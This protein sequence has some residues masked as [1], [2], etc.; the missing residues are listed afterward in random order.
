[1]PNNQLKGNVF[2]P[3]EIK[4]REFNSKLLL[5]SR[6]IAEGF[7]VYIGEKV[8]LDEYVK[9]S[10]VKG[11]GIY[12]NKSGNIS[13]KL[14]YIEESF[15]AMVVLDEEMGVAVKDLHFRYSERLRNEELISKYFVI[16]S[17]HAEHLKIF[18]KKI[19]EKLVVT[20]WPRVDLWRPMLKNV[21]QKKIDRLI[22]ENGNFILFSSDFGYTSEDRINFECHQRLKKNWSKERVETFRKGAVKKFEEYKG[23]IDFLKKLSTQNNAPT[24]IVRPHPAENHDAW[25]ED[26]KNIPNVKVI[27][28]GEITP[29][30][31]ASQGV[32]HRG[33]TTGFQAFVSGKKSFYWVF[34]NGF[35]RKE[36]LSY[37]VS[38]KFSTPSELIE[39]IC[40][41]AVG[42]SGCDS[43]ISSEVDWEVY[44]D[45]H[46]L[47]TD[48]I[49]CEIKKIPVAKSGNIRLNLLNKILIFIKFLIYKIR[50]DFGIGVD[51]NRA[52]RLR[53]KFGEGI[54]ANEISEFLDAMN[55][56]SQY[57]LTN[58]GRN[59][60]EIEST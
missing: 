8:S 13:K 30:V 32:I 19:T 21:Y 47:A 10:K 7:R 56:T 59:L 54:Q 9:A 22:F 25:R 16:S 28:E 60:Y 48:L 55:L 53:N 42:D 27:Y 26:A 45:P 46:K 38:E 33:C 12:F 18:N 40:N 11:G 49:V 2:L 5:A 4:A 58:L 31:Y 35:D 51:V 41:N 23:F 43:K 17:K 15:E 39:A 44:I 37:K 3:L 20:G 34:E 57:K 52:E 50:Y 6:L 14:K 29:W 36:L 24:I 1:M